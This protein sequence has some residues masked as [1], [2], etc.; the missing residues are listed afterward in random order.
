[1]VGQAPITWRLQTYAGPA[2]GEHVIKPAIDQFNKVAEGQMQIELYY[3]D[4]LVPPP[5][6]SARCSAAPSTRCS[7]T[8]TRWQSPTE[9]TVF[10]GYFPFASRYSLD[11]PVLFNQYGLAEIWDEEYSK[12]GVKHISA[13]AWDPC[14][15][16]TKDPIN[17]LA[18]LSGKRVF[19]FPTAGRF[20]TQFGVVPVTLPWEDIEVAVQT[21]ELDGVAWSGITEDYTVGWANVPT[22]S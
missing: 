6:C 20:L 12:V 19:T 22:T 5:S 11:V 4:Q 10:G 14:H 15:F 1:M 13:G 2:L 9:V 16:A 7:P 8:T 18:D 3:A 17:T 21:G